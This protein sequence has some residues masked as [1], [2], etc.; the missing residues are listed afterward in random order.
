MNKLEIEQ[1]L[2]T[3]TEK[4]K[5]T[6]DQAEFSR[7]PVSD[8]LEAVVPMMEDMVEIMRAILKRTTIEP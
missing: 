4:L 8:A 3:M 6:K 1:K 5:D 7:G 2:D